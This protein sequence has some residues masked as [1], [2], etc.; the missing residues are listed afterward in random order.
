MSKQVCND[1][2]FSRI[3]ELPFALGAARYALQHAAHLHAD[4]RLNDAGVNQQWTIHE[5][6]HNGLGRRQLS[7][8]LFC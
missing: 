8:V 5:Q 7:G 1:G 3:L 6:Q 4:R 2:L